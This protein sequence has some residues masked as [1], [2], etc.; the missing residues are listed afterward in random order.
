[1]PVA[2]ARRI[3][4]SYPTLG[5]PAQSS[6]R[7][8]RTRV[9]DAPGVAFFYRI[10]GFPRH[11]R[12]PRPTGRTRPRGAGPR[13]TTDNGRVADRANDE[14]TG[15]RPRQRTTPNAP[16]DDGRGAGLTE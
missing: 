9:L 6:R 11:A 16:V 5:V 14:G 13:A 15:R 10:L 3:P 8:T 12:I 7:S 2:A 4:G 1:M